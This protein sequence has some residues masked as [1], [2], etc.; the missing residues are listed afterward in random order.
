[1]NP[2][3]DCGRPIGECPWLSHGRPVEGWEAESVR[4][5][6]NYNRTAKVHDTYAIRRCPLMIPAR[7]REHGQ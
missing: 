4:R 1:M 5:V 3:G 7:R 2:C 6:L